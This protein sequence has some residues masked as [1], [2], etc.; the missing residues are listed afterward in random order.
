MTVKHSSPTFLFVLI[1]I[2]LLPAMSIAI[3]P[4]SEATFLRHTE[5]GLMHHV[6]TSD[7]QSSPSNNID[8]T[9]N[10]TYNLTDAIY[11]TA[12]IA[13]HTYI[14]AGSYLNIPEETELFTIEGA[15]SPEWTYSG[16]DFYT[17]ASDDSTTLAAI[18]ASLDLK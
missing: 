7:V 12:A 5:H 1:L 10:W 18:S 15:G 6:E 2:C 16:E 13:D 14:L 9:L 11:R 3:T 17:D 4:T 8:Q